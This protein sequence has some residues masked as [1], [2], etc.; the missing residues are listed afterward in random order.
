MNFL[1]NYSSSS[2]SSSEDESIKHHILHKAIN[3]RDSSM[4]PNILE[5]LNI[6]TSVAEKTDFHNDGDVIDLPVPK[7]IAQPAEKPT[8]GDDDM[9]GPPVPKEFVQITKE[10]DD[11]V[12][13]PSVP[14]EFAQ[15]AQD[16]AHDDDDVIGPS[17]PKEFIEAAT[18]LAQDD[19]NDVIG[20]PVPSY[21]QRVNADLTTPNQFATSV[22]DHSRKPTSSDESD[23]DD[24]ES[25]NLPVSYHADF[26]HGS[27]AVTAL[28]VDPTGTRFATGSLDYEVR[29]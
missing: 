7:E 3:Q 18:K 6:T 10:D 25:Y 15:T 19:D 21:L 16:T 27:K 23:D 20:P 1:A 2:G 11:D 28:A 13:G 22:E 8:Y 24:V 4:P 9:I 17:I 5:T 14:K 26:K 12:I 29:F